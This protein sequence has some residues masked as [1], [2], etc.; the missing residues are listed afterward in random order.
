V[1]RQGDGLLTDLTGETNIQE[2][3]E[4]LRMAKGC[5][6][7][8][9]G[10]MH[11]AAMIG[12]PTVAIFGMRIAPTWWFPNSDKIISI[13]AITECS[14]CYNDYCESKDCLNNIEVD[15]VTQSLR[16]LF[17]TNKFSGTSRSYTNFQ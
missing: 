13:F 7:N 14:Y 12:V 15:H 2:L 1:V 9:T 16:E 17:E 8:D 11:L 10:T 6:T 4:L 3:I 5:V